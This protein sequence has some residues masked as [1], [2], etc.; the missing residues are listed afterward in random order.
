MT[1]RGRPRK[2]KWFSLQ[3]LEDEFTPEAQ[4]LKWASANNVALQTVASLGCPKC[5]T[6]N[7]EFRHDVKYK[8]I[9]FHCRDC[10]YETS[11]RV[12]VP[13]PGSFEVVPVLKNGIQVD[14]VI[15]D[16]YHPATLRQ[17]SDA[18]VLKF[19]RGVDLGRVNLGGEW[20]VDE[21]VGG[22]HSEKRYYA[23]VEEVRLICSWNRRQAQLEKR[24]CELEKDVHV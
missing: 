5:F 16:S 11:Y 18:I 14:E 1:Q 2:H 3:Q 23:N 15:V 4:Y 7:V 22:V 9:R 19:N 6:D 21:R 12:Q 10:R 17:R 13:K 8:I 20:Y 24:L